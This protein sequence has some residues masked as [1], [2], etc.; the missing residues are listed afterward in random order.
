MGETDRKGKGGAS[1]R[2]LAAP[3]ELSF[4][5]CSRPQTQENWRDG[6]YPRIFVQDYDNVDEVQKGMKSAGFPGAL[7]NPLAEKVVWNL[8]RELRA[9]VLGEDPS[10]E[11]MAAE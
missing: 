3:V 1:P 5:S 6:N 4:S 2:N 10:A 7:P 11:L 9:M 8:H